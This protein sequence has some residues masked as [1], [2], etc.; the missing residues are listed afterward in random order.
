MQCGKGEVVAN[1]QRE[2]GEDKIDK[3]LCLESGKKTQSNV[4]NKVLRRKSINKCSYP[5]S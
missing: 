4:K 3:K 1:V 5:Q 2:P